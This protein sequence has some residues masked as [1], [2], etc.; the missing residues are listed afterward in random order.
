MHM[1]STTVFVNCEIFQFRMKKKNSMLVQ[2]QF[3]GAK[4]DPKKL[5]K[6]QNCHPKKCAQ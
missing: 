4:F 2:Q 6:T 5:Q 1:L 3:S